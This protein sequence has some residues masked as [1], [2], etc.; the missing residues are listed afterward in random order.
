MPLRRLLSPLFSFSPF[1]RV[2]FPTEADSLPSETK[3]IG[4]CS[5]GAL[6]LTAFLSFWVVVFL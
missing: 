2:S 1:L 4:L 5:S 3:P 6:S